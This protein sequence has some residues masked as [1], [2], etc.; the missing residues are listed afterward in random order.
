[1]LITQQLEENPPENRSS[2][3]VLII[4]SFVKMTRSVLGTLVVAGELDNG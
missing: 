3:P 4:T 2:C 1:V